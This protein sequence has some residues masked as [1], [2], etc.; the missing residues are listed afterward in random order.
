MAAPF[1]QSDAFASIGGEEPRAAAAAGRPGHVV[2]TAGGGPAE[3]RTLDSWREDALI[4]DRERLGLSAGVSGDRAPRPLRTHIKARTDAMQGVPASEFTDRDGNFTYPAVYA[5]IDE[6]DRRAAYLKTLV[7]PETGATPFGQI[8]APEWIAPW[9]EH[10]EALKEE[11]T[12]ERWFASMF[13]MKDPWQKQ[14]S[15]QLLP[16]FWERREELLKAKFDTVKRAALL[17]LRGPKTK[18]DLIFLY[19]LQTGRIK[20]PKGDFWMPGTTP[21]QETSFKRGL[22]NIWS[23]YLPTTDVDFKASGI[24]RVLDP[25]TGYRHGAAMPHIGG[26]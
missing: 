26:Y 23:K 14:M 18:E 21:E 16:E 1:T 19:G 2:R 15:Q 24:G 4:N 8:F 22:F 3:M 13:D 10:K 12:F 9:L 6:R 20:I 11:E 25:A 17:N 5:D 7:N